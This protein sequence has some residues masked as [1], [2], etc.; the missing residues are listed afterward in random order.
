MNAV[1]VGTSVNDTVEHSRDGST[2]AIQ[3]AVDA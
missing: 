2:I 1:I 3:V